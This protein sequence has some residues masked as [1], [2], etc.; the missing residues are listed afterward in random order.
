MVPQLYHGSFYLNRKKNKNQYN[1]KYIL[2]KSHF[3]G[4]CDST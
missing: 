2:E 4:I 1:V 3:S